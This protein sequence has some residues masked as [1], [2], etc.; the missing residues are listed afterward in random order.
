MYNEYNQ[1]YLAHHGIVGQKWGKRNGP[2]YPLNASTHNRVVKRGKKVGDQPKGL[3]KLTVYDEKTAKKNIRKQKIVRAAAKATPFVS[4][5][6]SVLNAAKKLKKYGEEKQKEAHKIRSGIDDAEIKKA[7]REG[8][9]VGGKMKDSMKAGLDTVAENKAKYALNVLL[10]TP[11]SKIQMNN[12]IIKNAFDSI[13]NDLKKETY[14]KMEK[15]KEENRKKYLENR[16]N[17]ESI[18]E[19]TGFYKKNKNNSTIAKDAKNSTPGSNYWT[20]FSDEEYTGN[21][22][23]AFAMRRK[24]LDTIVGNN[25]KA[26]ADN[27]EKI[28]DKA[29]GKG[30]V[31]H[32]DD[33]SKID[34]ELLEWS[35]LKNQKNANGIL[36]CQRKNGKKDTFNYTVTNGKFKYI[37]VLDRACYGSN[38]MPSNSTDSYGDTNIPRCDWGEF[39]SSY[40]AY[41]HIIMIRTDN[42]SSNDMD[43]QELKKYII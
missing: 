7:E 42:L 15:N 2:P 18:D 27:I 29:V 9:M 20:R 16:K 39:I 32:I 5:A 37:D 36:L 4:P 17:T 25:A 6:F 23:L 28:F 13:K 3:S 8:R 19:D 24:G 38:G 22:A 26:S 34:N 12:E 30:N 31:F 1:Y 21:M 14:D 35:L 11:W 43:I 33:G 40:P 41:D 10:G